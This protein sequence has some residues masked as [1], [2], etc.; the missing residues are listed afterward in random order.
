MHLL[1]EFSWGKK[2][3]CFA[4]DCAMSDNIIDA[5]AA[6]VNGTTSFGKV[7]Q[8]CN[9]SYSGAQSSLMHTATRCNST[10][11]CMMYSLVCAWCAYCCATSGCP[12]RADRSVD[13]LHNVV[14]YFST[15]SKAVSELE[16]YILYIDGRNYTYT[17]YN[18]SIRKDWK[19]WMI[20]DLHEIIFIN[21]EN[22]WRSLICIETIYT[23]QH[24]SIISRNLLLQ[25]QE[26]YNPSSSFLFLP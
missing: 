24:V 8:T 23:I 26:F 19:L 6:L 2:P 21:F 7:Q 16:S 11:I 15:S 22:D 5:R 3:C 20:S 18:Y 4:I 9:I 1:S 25:H 14:R 17:I 10:P 12:W 13:L